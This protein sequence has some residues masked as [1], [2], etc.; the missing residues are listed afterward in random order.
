MRKYIIALM[1]VLMTMSFSFA[2]SAAVLEEVDSTV[3]EAEPSIVLEQAAPEPEL[4][5]RDAYVLN[6]RTSEKSKLEIR[7]KSDYLGLVLE[8][9]NGDIVATGDDQVNFNLIDEVNRYNQTSA[10]KLKLVGQNFS[11]LTPTEQ[12]ANSEFAKYF[13][14][15]V[16]EENTP[17]TNTGNKTIVTTSVIEEANNFVTA[18]TMIKN[19]SRGY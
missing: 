5:V 4:I 6:R 17:V 2:A 3:I 13:V 11:A 19:L 8:L 18:I 1:A 14:Y 7:D 10:R 15:E 12:S 9:A 16:Q